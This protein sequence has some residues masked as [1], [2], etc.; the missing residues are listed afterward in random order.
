MERAIQVEKVSAGK[1]VAQMYRNI[2][3]WA[4][5]SLILGSLSIVANGFFDP[6]WGILLVA[7]A[8]LSWKVKLPSKQEWVNEKVG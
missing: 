3:G 4:I 8:I 1:D 7:V 2:R 5:A 6:V